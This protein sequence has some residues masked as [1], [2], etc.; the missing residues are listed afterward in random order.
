MNGIN[1]ETQLRHQHKVSRDITSQELNNQRGKAV[2][3]NFSNAHGTK[4]VKV[5]NT[6]FSKVNEQISVISEWGAKEKKIKLKEPIVWGI[7][8]NN[9]LPKMTQKNKQ[10]LLLAHE[11]S[12]HPEMTKKYFFKEGKYSIRNPNEE[13]KEEKH[14]STE[15]NEI[16][17]PKSFVPIMLLGKGSFGEVYLVQK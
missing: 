15:S 16:I 4:F 3:Q 10:D 17:G 5:E 13:S 8:K 1:I 9:G 12:F 7:Y 2:S 14:E 11:Q 6:I